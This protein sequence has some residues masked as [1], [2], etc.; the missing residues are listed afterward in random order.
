[1]LYNGYTAHTDGVES[2][3]HAAG[4][5]RQA[6]G[7]APAALHVDPGAGG[8]REALAAQ[9]GQGLW[10]G[11]FSGTVEPTSGDFS[12][13]AKSARLIRDGARAGA[14]G[15]TLISGNVFEGLE[16]LVAMSDRAE[17]VHGGASVPW[18][19]VDGVSVTGG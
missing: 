6:P 5:P 7:I 14:V 17:R 11:R 13:V 4:G 19:I 16:R 9:I 2:T 1:L 18:A 15:E 3:G 12:G 8:D 10:V